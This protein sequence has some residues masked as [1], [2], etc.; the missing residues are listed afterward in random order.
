MMPDMSSGRPSGIKPFE[1]PPPSS[2]G[3]ES[4]AAASTPGALDQPLEDGRER[5]LRACTGSPYCAAGNATRALSTPVVS[6]PIG[7]ACRLI[8]LRT[9][10]AAPA[11][12]MSTSAACAAISVW[13]IQGRTDAPGSPFAFAQLVAQMRRVG[14][15]ASPAAIRR[16]PC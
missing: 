1:P 10:S 6:N 13:R 12:T 9:S 7:T 15:S 4:S 2:G 8:A 11:R 16:A 14:S 5:R 3:C